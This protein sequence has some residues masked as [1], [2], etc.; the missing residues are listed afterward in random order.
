M[1]A[2]DAHSHTYAPYTRCSAWVNTRRNPVSTHAASGRSITMGLLVGMLFYSVGLNQRSVQVRER[3][4]VAVCI[5]N[6]PSV[7]GCVYS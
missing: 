7:C 4:C 1:Y 3:V 2:F 6:I 5:R